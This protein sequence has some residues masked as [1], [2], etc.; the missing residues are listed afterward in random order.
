MSEEQPSFRLVTDNS[1]FVRKA[2]EPP[3]EVAARDGAMAEVNVSAMKLNRGKEGESGDKAAAPPSSTQRDCNG[4]SKSWPDN[5]LVRRTRKE[6]GK[7]HELWICPVCE[8]NKAYEE[9]GSEK[10]RVRGSNLDTTKLFM[11]FAIVLVVASGLI[12]WKFHSDTVDQKVDW[13]TEEWASQPV[14]K[15]PAMVGQWEARVQGVPQPVRGQGFL[16]ERRDGSV[17]AVGN[18]EADW[19]TTQGIKIKKY[20]DLAGKIQTSLKVPGKGEVK[21]TDVFRPKEVVLGTLWAMTVSTPAKDLPGVP[22]KVRRQTFGIGLTGTLVCLVGAGQK[23][24]PARIIQGEKGSDQFLLE[25]VKPIPPDSVRGAVFIDEFGHILAIGAEVMKTPSARTEQRV[26]IRN[27][28][29]LLGL[30]K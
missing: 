3:V 24:Y 1:A 11:I 7:E 15:W 19:F 26:Y 5:Y 17:V 16:L 12:F 23:A 14:E 8:R 29:P 2:G 25:M 18:M 30:E 13:I 4:C 20:G 10:V 6:K 21:S 28:L 22:L 9:T 27:T